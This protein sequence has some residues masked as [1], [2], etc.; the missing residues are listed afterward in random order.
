[1]TIKKNYNGMDTKKAKS[2]NRTKIII[3][4]HPQP[5]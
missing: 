1:M 4:P 5:D 2:T 3:Q